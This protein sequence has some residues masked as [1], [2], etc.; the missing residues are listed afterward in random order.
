MEFGGNITDHLLFIFDQNPI[1][2]CVGQSS[3]ERLRMSILKQKIISVFL[4]AHIHLNPNMRKMCFISNNNQKINYGRWNLKKISCLCDK[5][6]QTC[7]FQGSKMPKITKC[8]QINLLQSLMKKCRR[9]V[10]PKR[11]HWCSSKKTIFEEVR[12]NYY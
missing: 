1:F 10:T 9:R 12:K 8:L 7:T 2:F 5:K 6:I 3:Y 4:C 11:N